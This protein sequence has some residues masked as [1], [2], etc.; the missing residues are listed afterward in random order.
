MLDHVRLAY[1]YVA[2]A[3]GDKATVE[4]QTWPDSANH[5]PLVVVGT[6]APVTLVNGPRAQAMSFQIVVSVYDEGIEAAYDLAR[7]ITKR[8]YALWRVGHT[9]AYGGITYIDRDSTYPER[10]TSSYR[11]PV[12]N[13]LETDDS[14][15]FDLTLNVTAHEI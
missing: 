4:M 6:S 2:D 1:A 11:Q 13:Q 8:L 7:Y 15:R 12:A 10:I 3:V 5:L 14:I 9:T